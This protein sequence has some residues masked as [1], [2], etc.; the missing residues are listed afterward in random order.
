MSSPR[1]EAPL[2][3]RGALLAAAL[4]L[5]GCQN[6]LARRDTVSAHAGDAIAANK[7]IHVVDPWPAAAARTDIPVSARRVVQAI[8]RYERGPGTEGPAPGGPIPVLP[9]VPPGPQ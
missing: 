1:T 5:A 8:D 3:R 7:A 2:L 4:L 9:A 6:S